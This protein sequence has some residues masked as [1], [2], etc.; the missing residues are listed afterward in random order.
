MSRKTSILT[1]HFVE[2]FGAVMQAFA[3][4]RAVSDICGNAEIIDYRPWQDIDKY[5]DLG[6]KR[7]FAK[8]AEKIATFRRDQMGICG[9]GMTHLTK[10]NAPNASVYIVG[11]DQVWNPL[12]TKYDSAYFLRFTEA[13]ACRISYA[14]SIGLSLQHPLIQPDIFEKNLKDFDFISVREQEYADYLEKLLNRKVCVTVDPVLLADREV[15][16]NLAASSGIERQRFVLLYDFDFSPSLI[17]YANQWARELDCGV[18]HFYSGVPNTLFF[19]DST[20]CAYDGVEE[21]LYYFKNAEAVITS[22][23]HGVLFSIIFGKDFYIPYT[24]YTGVRLG[25][26]LNTYGLVDRVI[27]GIFLPK[28][29]TV[30]AQEELRRQVVIEREKSFAFLMEALI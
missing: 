25:S 8:K 1:F 18:V 16:A 7:S 20:S 26:L 27:D 2:N 15:Y 5:N 17:D 9:N 11:S 24:A 29:M 13:P 30:E 19:G 10:E 28:K 21:I 23:Y 22:S 3:L 12:Y 6:V 4:R 14:A